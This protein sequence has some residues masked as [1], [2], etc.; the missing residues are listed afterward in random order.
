MGG[1]LH[2]HIV[3]V[4]NLDVALLTSVKTW[5]KIAAQI[6]NIDSVLF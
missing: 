4:I 2:D 3:A 6:S 1:I 5:K